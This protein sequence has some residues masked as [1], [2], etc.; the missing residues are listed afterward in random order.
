[1]TSDSF[2]RI[3]NF[4]GNSMQFDLKSQRLVGK[5]INFADFLWNNNAFTLENH[6]FKKYQPW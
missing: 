1:M 3:R 6:A 5:I 4:I 2:L